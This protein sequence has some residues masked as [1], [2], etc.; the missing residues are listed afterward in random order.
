[1]FP[2]LILALSK[3]STNVI[4]RT[5]AVQGRPLGV[6]IQIDL[7]FTFTEPSTTTCRIADNAQVYSQVAAFADERGLTFPILMDGDSTVSRLYQVRAMPST[8]FIDQEGIIREVTLGG[9]MS[10]GF[11][12][13]QVATLLAGGGGD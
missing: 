12:E 5:R 4:F 1:M 13:S 8:F 3:T 10:E 11:I 9:P 2:A 6:A 7:H